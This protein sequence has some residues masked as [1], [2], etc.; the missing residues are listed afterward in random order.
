MLETEKLILRRFHGQKEPVHR[1]HSGGA[2]VRPAGG[3]RSCPHHPPCIT[4][5]GPAHPPLMRG[6]Q[7]G[8][9]VPR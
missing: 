9:K 5:C 1:S 4:A 8:T 6:H 7:V 2:S 3:D